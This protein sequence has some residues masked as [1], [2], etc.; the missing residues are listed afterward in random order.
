M[1]TIAISTSA[2]PNIANA[3]E[4]AAVATTALGSSEL[5]KKVATFAA[6]G[7]V[8]LVVSNLL[9]TT[10]K[11]DL[12]TS[13]IDTVFPGALKNK[14]L[15]SKVSDSLKKYGYGSKSLVA[16]SLCA[17]EVNRVLEKDFSAVYDDNFSMGGLA[18][19]VWR[20]QS[21]CIIDEL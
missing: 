9:T 2:V 19:T 20:L 15:V 4:E 3:K 5:I 18:G 7:A 17:D 12:C 10:E 11:S 1:G 16:T 8:A 21:L 14:K 6:G 13:K